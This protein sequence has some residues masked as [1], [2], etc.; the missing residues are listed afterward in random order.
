MRVFHQCARCRQTRLMDE[1]ATVCDQCQEE[2]ATTGERHRLIVTCYDENKRELDPV[3][4]DL[5]EGTRSVDC[6]IRPVA[7]TKEDTDV[8]G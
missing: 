7:T 6:N 1:F 5:P 8:G 4:I 3:I 2:M